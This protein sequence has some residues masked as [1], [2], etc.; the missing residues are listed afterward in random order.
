MKRFV[1]SLQDLCLNRIAFAA[2]LAPEGREWMSKCDPRRENTDQ[3]FLRERN[4]S[5]MKLL[6]M[7]FLDL[8]PDT[9]PDQFLEVIAH[10]SSHLVR[11][12]EKRR[13]QSRGLLAEVRWRP[14]GTIDEGGF[15]RVLLRNPD[16][17]PILRFLMAWR[18]FWK[19]DIERLWGEMPERVQKEVEEVTQCHDVF[20]NISTWIQCVRE[21]A[22]R[23]S[24]WLRNE[25]KF[26]KMA[27]RMNAFVGLESLMQNLTPKAKK[28]R[29]R[30]LYSN[31]GAP[32]E[33]FDMYLSLSDE[34]ERPQLIKKNLFQILIQYLEWPLRQV[35][36]D[37]LEWTREYITQEV[38]SRLLNH[39]LC[40]KI[41]RDKDVKC[42]LH[43][44]TCVLDHGTHAQKEYAKKDTVH[45]YLHIFLTRGLFELHNVLRQTAPNSF[46]PISEKPE[47]LFQ[48]K[49]VFWIS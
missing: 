30:S 42:Y 13:L 29:L 43:L 36:G 12:F 17:D 14:E 24:V 21:G 22:D 11:F 15:T 16:C 25:E 33:V 26:Y 20:A 40:F 38:F 2:L 7:R 5:F 45:P 3:R 6:R 31:A 28:S 10:K 44:F 9:L 47:V 49:P 34:N 46:F 27:F 39:I 19:E 35:Y 18:C 41:L 23:D 8:M 37:V 4:A 48:G 1:L 32:F